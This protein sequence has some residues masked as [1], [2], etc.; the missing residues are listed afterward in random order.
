MKGLVRDVGKEY[1]TDLRF[2]N[3]VYEALRV[4]SEDMITSIFVNAKKIATE[5]KRPQTVKQSDVLLAINIMNLGNQL[6]TIHTPPT[7]HHNDQT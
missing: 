2:E 7:T 3:K 1:K 6:T 4:A 5:S